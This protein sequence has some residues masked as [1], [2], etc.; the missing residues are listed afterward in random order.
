[1]G[2]SL[3]GPLAKLARAERQLNVLKD[4]IEAVWPPLKP[5]PVH[6]ESHRGGLEYRFYLGDVP[7]VEP[8]WALLAGEIMFDL[9]SALDHL[10]WELHVRHYGRRVIP[11][12]V[13]FASQFPIFDDRSEF[14]RRGQRRI[15]ELAKREQR[16]IRALQPYV[17]RR[18]CWHFVR[19]D[20]SYLNALHNIDKHRKLHVV[21]GAQGSAVI[22][23]F[24][25]DVGFRQ[26]FWLGAVK[27]HSQVETWTFSVPPAEMQDHGGALLQIGFEYSGSYFDLEPLLAGLVHSVALVVARFANRFP[28][29]A[30]PADSTYLKLFT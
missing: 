21:A 15:K 12:K 9:R 28:P 7:S 17:R 6:A 4:E 1:M 27:S 14:V 22:Q 23:A 5:W 30:P 10:A 11:E 16:A 24:S 26:Q 8:D 20:L 13:E 18:D 3:E 19:S 29:A 25:R 2:A